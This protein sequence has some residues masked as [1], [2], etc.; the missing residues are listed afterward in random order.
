MYQRQSKLPQ[1]ASKLLVYGAALFWFVVTL[2]P[3]LFLAQNSMKAATEFYRASVWALPEKISLENYLQIW[4]NQI[5]RYFL[6]SIFLSSSSLLLILIVASAAAFGLARIRFRGN[7]ALYLLFV[8]GLTIPVHVTL[9]PVYTITKNLGLYDTL[10]ALIGPYVAAAMPTTV[11]ILTA[12]MKGIPRSLEEAAYI[13]GASRWHVYWHVVLPIS[14][15]AL[16]AVGIF[17]LVHVWNEFIFALTLLSS[18]KVRP[19]PLA[20]WDFQGQ[21][22]ADVPAMMAALLVSSLPVLLL[23]GIA[24]ERLI[25]GLTAGAI[26]G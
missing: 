5:W 16:T 15:P 20:L 11:F 17:N 8:G 3:F 23:Y 2:Y 1:R 9:I 25:E 7:T 18:E 21:Y 14:R 24:K 6:N 13:D 22:S 19:L 4:E 10:W 26:K 12:F